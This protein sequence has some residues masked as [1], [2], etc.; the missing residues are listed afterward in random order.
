MHKS[1]NLDVQTVR[2]ESRDYCKL[3]TSID[4]HFAYFVVRHFRSFFDSHVQRFSSPS[5]CRCFTQACS[6]SSLVKD[7]FANIR[8]EERI[9]ALSSKF[10]VDFVNHRK[11]DFVGTFLSKRARRAFFVQFLGGCNFSLRQNIAKHN[12]S[13]AQ[14]IP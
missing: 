2:C 7:I 13:H 10:L 9:V 12:S 14:I 8:N 5:L 1:S 4:N 3:S 11:N 6:A